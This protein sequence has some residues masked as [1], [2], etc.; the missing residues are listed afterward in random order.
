MKIATIVSLGHFAAGVAKAVTGG[1][2]PAYPILGSEADNFFIQI[3][4]GPDF[5]GREIVKTIHINIAPSITR[6]GSPNAVEVCLVIPDASYLIALVAL[7][8]KSLGVNAQ[9]HPPLSDNGDFY[10]DWD[11]AIILA[12]TC[13][14]F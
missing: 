8:E 14:A 12:S 6:I 3:C 2:N 13:T 10:P 4:R 5:I 1:D 9:I 11:T 7:L